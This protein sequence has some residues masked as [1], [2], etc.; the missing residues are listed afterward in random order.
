MPHAVDERDRTAPRRLFAQL[1]ELAVEQHDMPQHQVAGVGP[2]QR[3]Q[4]LRLGQAVGHRLLQQHDLPGP[5]QRTGDGNVSRRRAG[6]DPRLGV[7]FCQGLL[8]ARP[9]A[10]AWQLGRDA[11]EA[12]LPPRDQ[13]DQLRFGQ[14][15]QRQ[16][17]QP[18]KPAQ[19]D[20]TDS[21]RFKDAC[22]IV[23]LFLRRHLPRLTQLVPEG[24]NGCGK[25]DGDEPGDLHARRAAKSACG[26]RLT[27]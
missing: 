14:A 21:D 8:Q 19:A 3:R 26:R 15:G 11:I 7:G 5:Q 13:G 25:A 27:D 1:L 24:G 16:R 23:Q 22:G 4:R 2:H 10:N 9:A 20:H 6:D 18:A 17:M 12:V